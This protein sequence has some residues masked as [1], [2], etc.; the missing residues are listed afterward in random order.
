MACGRPNRSG[1][2]GIELRVQVSARSGEV[3]SKCGAVNL[4]PATGRLISEREADPGDDRIPLT[5]FGDGIIDQDAVHV[6]VAA[7]VPRPPISNAENQ[8]ISETVEINW[9]GQLSFRSLVPR[10]GP[11]SPLA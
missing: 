8:G 5:I 10:T 11:V 7:V 9:G 1:Q 2:P 3:R 6:F 4:F